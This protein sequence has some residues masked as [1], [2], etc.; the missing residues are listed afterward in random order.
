MNKKFILVGAML[1]TI[2]TFAQETTTSIDEVTIAS[3]TPQQLSKT[4]KNIK[5]L[6]AKEL[7]KYKGQNLNDVLN[8]VAGLQITGNYNNSSEPKFGKIRGGKSANILILIDGVPLKDVTGNDYNAA[9]LRLIAL[10][11]IDSIEVM[12]GAASVLYGSN[13]TVSVINIT[14]KKGSAKPV[15]GQVELRAG[16]YSTFAQEAGVR[17]KINHFNYQISGFNEKSQGFSSAD[18]PDTFDKDGWE[19]QNLSANVGLTYDRFKISANA[20]YNH[21]LFLFDNG[22]YTDGNLRSNDSQFYI[23]ATGQFNYNSK[24]G[25]LYFNVRHTENDRLVQD[26]LT[27]RYEDQYQYLGRNFFAEVYNSYKFNEN[28]DLTAG[29]QYEKQAMTYNN[30]PWGGTAMEEVLNYKDTSIEMMDVFAKAHYQYQGFNIDAG[31][32]FTNHSKFNNHVI[33]SVNPYY[34]HDFGSTFLKAGVSYATAYIA[35]TLYQNYGSK[36]WIMPN[37]EL[38]PETNQSWEM[39]LAFGKS[40]RS[41]VA[42]ASLFLRNEKDVFTYVLNPDYTG[43]FYNIDENKVKGFEIGLDY[44]II[45]KLKIGG[46]YSFVEKDKAATMLRQPKHRVNSYVEYLPT[47]TTRLFLTHQFVGKRLDA[48]FDSV[49]YSTKNIDLDGFHLF[50]LNI[51]QKITS[52]ISAYANV[53]NL[54][55][56]SYIDVIG[57]TVKNRNYT[58]GFNYNF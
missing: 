56:T 11:N 54:F 57:Y 52:K 24:K 51:N 33:Y 48:F 58:I 12:N 25:N 1:V 14:T 9:D 13:A 34:L 23:G 4:G 7:E 30:L 15:E 45:P 38:K 37:F 17:G 35:P 16:S 8:Q 10:E 36:P 21:H 31:A 20:G 28:F 19:K 46:N 49:D 18:G 32:R 27:D 3:K 40:D 26:K 55:N 41:L 39:D 29:V 22:A 43:I 6:N 44:Q 5:L 2:S 50:N 53:G 42:T 47:A